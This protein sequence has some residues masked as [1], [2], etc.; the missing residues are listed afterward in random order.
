MG[1]SRKERGAAD[2]L[3][4]RESEKKEPRRAIKRKKLRGVGS[5]I[6]GGFLFGKGTKKVGKLVLKRGGGGEAETDAE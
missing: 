4:A 5:Q 3:R 2:S 1:P 6:C